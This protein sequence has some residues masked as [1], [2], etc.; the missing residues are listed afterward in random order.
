MTNMYNYICICTCVC[1]VNK[2][3]TYFNIDEFRRSDEKYDWTIEQLSKLPI[4]WYGGADLSK[5]HDL[6][7]AALFGNYKGVDIIITHAWFL[8]TCPK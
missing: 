6:T 8:E 2:L 1:V 7:T 4:K 5:L 3:C